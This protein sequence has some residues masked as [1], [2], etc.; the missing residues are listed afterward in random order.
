MEKLGQHEAVALPSADL[1]DGRWVY[2]VG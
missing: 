1:A 2:D